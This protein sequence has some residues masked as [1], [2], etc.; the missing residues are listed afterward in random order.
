MLYVGVTYQ[1]HKTCFFDAKASSDNDTEN[2]RNDRN[3]VQMY[4]D[5]PRANA[6]MVGCRRI[7]LICPLQTPYAPGVAVEGRNI[8]VGDAATRMCALER[9]KREV[10]E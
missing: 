3:I 4:M 1:G 5:A 8:H 7:Y 9:K 2:Y 10:D 6:R